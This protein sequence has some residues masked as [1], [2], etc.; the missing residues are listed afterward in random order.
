[1]PAKITKRLKVLSLI[2]RVK[3]KVLRQYEQELVGAI[4]G[5]IVKGNS[6]VQ[7]GGKNSTSG[8]VRFADY[9]E[10]YKKAITSG[11][12]SQFGKKLRK[13][14]LT[15][16]GQMLDSL[17]ARVVGDRVRIFFKDTKARFHD[18][19]GAGKSKTIRRLLPRTGERFVKAITDL[20]LEILSKAI[21]KETRN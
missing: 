20:K 10:S 1:M 12:Y 18:L 6:P 7:G 11:R 17:S 21:S 3:P 4:K 14:N 15:L 2:D 5:A 9:S 8:R 19:E 16:S 13:I